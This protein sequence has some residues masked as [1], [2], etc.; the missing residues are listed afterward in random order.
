MFKIRAWE[1][2]KFRIDY[3][4]QQVV[5]FAASKSRPLLF[6]IWFQFTA[7]LLQH[8]DI[9]ER[10]LPENLKLSIAMKIEKNI[11]SKVVSRSLGCGCYLMGSDE[12][13][14]ILCVSEIK[15]I[16]WIQLIF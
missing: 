2:Y 8:K 7:V 10:R 5:P 3:E 4:N 6:P 16:L 12:T 14:I 9:M 11:F 1:R 13:C 15:L